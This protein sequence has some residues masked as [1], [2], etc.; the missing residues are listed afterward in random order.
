MGRGRSRGRQRAR[1][2]SSRRVSRI[3][4]YVCHFGKRPDQRAKPANGEEG[5]G[6]VGLLEKK[7]NRRQIRGETQTDPGWK[8]RFRGEE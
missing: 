2:R 8:P 4:G 6:F 5:G 3:G 7:H 1:G